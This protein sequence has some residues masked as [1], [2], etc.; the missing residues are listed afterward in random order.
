MSFAIDGATSSLLA[1]ATGT[2][3]GQYL[4]LSKA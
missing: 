1:E 4:P 2:L 3:R